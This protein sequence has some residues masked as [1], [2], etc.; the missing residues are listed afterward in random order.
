MMNIARK[1]NGRVANRMSITGVAKYH[2]V[3]YQLGHIYYW[4]VLGVGQS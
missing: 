3:A 2:V 4:W 1:N